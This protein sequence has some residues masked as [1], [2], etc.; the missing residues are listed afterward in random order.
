MVRWNDDRLDDLKRRVD[1]HDKPVQSVAVLTSRMQELARQL[2]ANT[3]GQQRIS[4]QFEDAQLEPF[5]RGRNF[6]SQLALAVVSAVA[7]GGLAVIGA[8]V[9]GAH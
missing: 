6:R 9:G 1:E 7:G 2:Q 8:I 3:D 4:K 5:K